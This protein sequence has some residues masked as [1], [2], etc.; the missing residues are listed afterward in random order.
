MSPPPSLPSAPVL[1]V[2]SPE[3]LKIRGLLRELQN[4]FAAGKVPLALISDAPDS[5]PRGEL[6]ATIAV[7]LLG[8]GFFASLYLRQ[9]V[10]PAL[11][12]AR[13]A[14]LQLLPWQLRECALGT[15]FVYETSDKRRGTA[16]L[17]GVTL[18]NQG[19]PPL[20]A[21][22]PWERDDCIA[23]AVATVRESLDAGHPPITLEPLPP[24]AAPTFSMR[25]QR[26]RVLLLAVLLVLP[27]PPVP[28]P[29]RLLIEAGMHRSAIDHIS[30]NAAG[31]I[32]VTCSHDKTVR[33]WDSSKLNLLGTIHPPSGQG[34]IGKLFATALSPDGK[35]IAAGGWTLAADQST[36]AIHLYDRVSKQLSRSIVGYPDIIYNLL[37][38]PDEPGI[39]AVGRRGSFFYF[40]LDASPSVV[41]KTDCQ[42]DSTGADI[43]HREKTVISC[44]DGKVRLYDSRWH[45][46]NTSPELR[47]KEP[48]TVRFSPDGTHV[49]V[50]YQDKPI[51]EV[52]PVPNL[53]PP[54]RPDLRG[55]SGHSLSSVA[56]SRDG[57]RLCAA[58]SWLMGDSS[59]VRCWEQAGHGKRSEWIVSAGAIS[60]LIALPDNQLA[61]AAAD[62]AWGVLDLI[63][64]KVRM[65]E[66]PTADF[67]DN[68]QGFL[69]DQDGQ[70]VRFAYRRHGKFPTTFS[71][72][73]RSLTPSPVPGPLLQ[74]ARITGIEVSDWREGDKARLRGETP[75][76]KPA[77]NSRCLAIASDGQ[78]FVLGT[79]RYL[80]AIAADGR[81]LWA[82]AA[83]GETS[84]VNITPDGRLVVAAFHDGTIR[85][86]RATSGKELLAFFPHIDRER[87]VLWT[88]ANF[89]DTSPGGEDLIY[90]V[91]PTNVD[92]KRLR[93]PEVISRAL[94]RETPETTPP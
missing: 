92:T 48:Y 52:L 43:Y 91:N 63:T 35:T 37:F 1:L 58:G 41:S 59:M 5:I 12:R 36:F 82:E 25:W 32:L 39:A 10:M 19:R 45:W 77:E 28:I 56:W 79:D 93:Q 61:F 83:P 53:D 71:V 30:T 88:P 47:G 73:E 3:D 54:F 60:D 62:P 51:V 8:P 57:Q 75:L 69:V 31:H 80:R 65:K 21:L 27:E 70:Q 18:I 66:S 68:L 34:H 9:Q 74:A 15:E 29:P 72:H 17:S 87:W 55:I 26:W 13:D 14:G 16:S 40:K 24:P 86:Y 67:S 81:N 94:D 90:W 6:N 2:F 7:L 38:S 49:A 42:R 4:Q 64:G 33:I 23:A 76:V 78:M 84:A 50:G 89:Y 85:W 46:I 11:L 20:R 22:T 44:M